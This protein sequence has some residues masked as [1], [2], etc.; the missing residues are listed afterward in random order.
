ML[1][2]EYYLPIAVCTLMNRWLNS[3]TEYYS[4]TVENFSNQN[5]LMVSV[6]YG[7]GNFRTSNPGITRKIIKLIVL[8]SKF[9]ACSTVLEIISRE[10]GRNGS[11]VTQ[12]FGGFFFF[13]KFFP[14]MICGTYSWYL[15]K[16][17]R[18]NPKKNS[19]KFRGGDR[20]AL[21]YSIVYFD[22]PI[23][24]RFQEE[25]GCVFCYF[26]MTILLLSNFLFF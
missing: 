21:I 3:I 25:R 2:I 4:Y 17:W 22:R 12:F 6:R 26:L 13:Q 1:I 19:D 18:R 23:C 8:N 5:G 24:I 10:T 9:L 20:G 7:T 14:K 11:S 16:D 15:L